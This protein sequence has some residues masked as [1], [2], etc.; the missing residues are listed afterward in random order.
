[1]RILQTHVLAVLNHEKRRCTYGALAGVLG[2]ANQDVGR[3]LGCHRPD[4][5][6]VVLKATGQPSGDWAPDQLAEGLC[7]GPEPISCPKELCR[8]VTEFENSRPQEQT[9]NTFLDFPM[10]GEDS[11][12]HG[13]YPKA[14]FSELIA[15][16]RR[17]PPGFLRLVGIIMVVDALITRIK[18]AGLGRPPSK[19]KGQP[20]TGE[21]ARFDERL[22]TFRKDRNCIVH[23]FLWRTS[24]D[25]S[26]EIMTRSDALMNDLLEHFIVVCPNPDTPGTIVLRFPEIW[27]LNTH[28][29]GHGC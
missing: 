15:Q 1:M 19:K 22:K 13:I 12:L 14:N 21:M 29:P 7:D 18:E 2:I 17:C 28:P 27:N 20:A 24:D 16:V 23:D 5:S 6:W 9:V 3:Y 11:R 8:R 4:A 25:V 10:M 26:E